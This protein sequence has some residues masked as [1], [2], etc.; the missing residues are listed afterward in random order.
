MNLFFCFNVGRMR[1]ERYGSSE[2]YLLVSSHSTRPQNPSKRAGMCLAWDITPTLARKTSSLQLSFIIMGTWSHG[3]ISP[4]SN[5]RNTGPSMSIMTWNSSKHV[6]LG[7]EGHAPSTRNLKY[8]HMKIGSACVKC[9]PPPQNNILARW[10]W[11]HRSKSALHDWFIV[12]FVEI[13]CLC[14]DMHTLSRPSI[15]VS[16]DSLYCHLKICYGMVGHLEQCYLSSRLSHNIGC[17]IRHYWNAE[18]NAQVE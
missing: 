17:C 16:V 2:L 12:C 11:V 3:L 10:E 14:L 4:W 18:G 8:I 7:T 1:T 13:C 5:T 6:I 9:P 15:F